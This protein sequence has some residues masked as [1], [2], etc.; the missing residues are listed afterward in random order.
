MLHNCCNS[1]PFSS[2]DKATTGT[3]SFVTVIGNVATWFLATL[4]IRKFADQVRM[5]LI[6][7]FIDEI[8][9]KLT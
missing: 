2:I 3:Q 5:R 9:L 6:S 4:D 1:F 7:Q 8:S